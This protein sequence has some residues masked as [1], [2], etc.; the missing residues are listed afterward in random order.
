[1]PLLDASYYLYTIACTRLVK[2]WL[3]GKI[4]DG[5]PTKNSERQLIASVNEQTSEHIMAEETNGTTDGEEREA[6]VTSIYNELVRRKV[7]THLR[8]ATSHR[9]WIRTSFEFFK[10]IGAKFSGDMEELIRRHDLSKYTPD[11]MLGYAVMFGDGQVGW[12]QL[13]TEDEKIEWNLALEHHYIHN[14]HHPEYFYV[15]REDGQ[16][17]KFSIVE[18]NDKGKLYME[19]S[20]ID[21][22][23]SKG[24]RN[25]KDDQTISIRKWL[26]IDEKYLKRY[27]E[28]DM[29]YVTELLGKW[30][31]LAEK[32]VAK[33]ANAD[34]LQMLFGRN[35]T[36]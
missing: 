34:Q 30:S 5:A 6:K 16:R 24:E 36:V 27:S 25:L 28:N 13:E 11:E 8:T 33:P 14:P 22:M 32:Y 35:V 19:E 7:L 20:V 10:M 1:M 4:G 12:K 21:M 31:E 2:E 23:A 17:A 15:K 26:D 9:K 3:T 18:E 29:K